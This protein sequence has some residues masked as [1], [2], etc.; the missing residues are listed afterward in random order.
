MNVK[1][2]VQ[3]MLFQA[4]AD[5]TRPE[6]ADDARRWI[7]GCDAPVTFEVVC[8]A[9]QLDPSRVRRALLDQTM[10]RSIQSRLLCQLR[11]SRAEE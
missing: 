7:E 6:F 10:S 1:L 8:Q 5:L 2:F 4:A 9:M 11:A 3:S